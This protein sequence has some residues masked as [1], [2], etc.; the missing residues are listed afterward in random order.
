V[1]DLE[2]KG[3]GDE[4]TCTFGAFNQFEDLGNGT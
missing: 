1:T 3:E 4:Q 2:A